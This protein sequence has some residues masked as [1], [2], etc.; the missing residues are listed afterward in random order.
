MEIMTG[1]EFKQFTRI[2]SELSSYT[3]NQWDDVY[4]WCGQDYAE[5]Y[6]VSDVVAGNLFEVVQTTVFGID[7]QGR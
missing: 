5:R 4:C 6:Q 2:L 7:S 1:K 3:D